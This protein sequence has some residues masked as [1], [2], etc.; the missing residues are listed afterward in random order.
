MLVNIV[1]MW[2]CSS[3]FDT[4][5]LSKIL[6]EKHAIVDILACLWIDKRKSKILVDQIESTNLKKIIFYSNSNS[7]RS[8]SKR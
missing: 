1:A 5:M 6:K 4:L 2:S 8:E 7:L 3:Y